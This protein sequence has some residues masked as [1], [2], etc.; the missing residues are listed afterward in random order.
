MLLRRPQPKLVLSLTPLIDV[1]FILLIFFMLVSQFSDWHEISFSTPTE[2]G[3]GDG[4]TMVPTLTLFK[5]GTYDIDGTVF[6]DRSRALV[7]AREVISGPSIQLSVEENVDIQHV[8]NT[9]ED[10]TRAGLADVR[11]HALPEGEAE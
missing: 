3:P 1:V 4:V 5:N 2:A 8:V 11:L 6:T 9:V 10:L 7:H